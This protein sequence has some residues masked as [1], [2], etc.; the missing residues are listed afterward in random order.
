M[1]LALE[2]SFKNDAFQEAPELEAARI[3]RSLADSFELEGAKTGQFFK[4]RD[5]NGNE[6]G[7]ALIVSR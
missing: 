6:A 4:L 2:M 5:V 3:L 7:S 1:R